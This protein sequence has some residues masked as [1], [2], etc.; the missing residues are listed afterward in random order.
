MVPFDK[1][2]MLGS[3]INKTLKQCLT[4]IIYL[5]LSGESLTCM[6]EFV[7]VLTCNIQCVFYLISE[8]KCLAYKINVFETGVCCFVFPVNCVFIGRNNQV[9]TCNKNNSCTIL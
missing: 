6:T 4:W 8:I 5:T 9:I 3:Y 2:K 7:T 1:N